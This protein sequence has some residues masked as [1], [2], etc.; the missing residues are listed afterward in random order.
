MKNRKI[1]EILF[2]KDYLWL[3]SLISNQ[4]K[5][6]KYKFIFP[7]SRCLFLRLNKAHNHRQKLSSIKQ[8]KNCIMLNEQEIVLIVSK[9]KR[10]SGECCTEY[11]PFCLYISSVKSEWNQSNSSRHWCYFPSV[12]ECSFHVFSQ[13][14]SSTIEICH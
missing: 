4:K 9:Q 6:C 1:K 2:R 8:K 7:K 3:S 5:V 10:C 12:H 13:Y 11:I 14:S